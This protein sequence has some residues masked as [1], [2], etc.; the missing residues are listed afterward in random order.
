MKR[1]IGLGLSVVG[2]VAIFEYLRRKGIVDQIKGE[3]KRFVGSVTDNEQLKTEGVI[4]TVK[5]KTLKVVDEVKHVAKETI[6]DINEAV[7]PKSVS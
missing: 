6:A 1:L 7:D 5:G 3:V 2:A 4:D